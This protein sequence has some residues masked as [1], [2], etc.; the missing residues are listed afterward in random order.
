VRVQTDEML[1]GG[2]VDQAE[3]RVV[4]GSEEVLGVRPGSRCA[5]LAASLASTRPNR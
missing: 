3:E 5:A 2:G 1:Q 4:A